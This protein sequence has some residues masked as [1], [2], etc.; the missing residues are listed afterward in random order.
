MLKT[1]RALKMMAREKF[2][3]SQ[4]RRAFAKYSKLGYPSDDDS[5]E[6]DMLGS[7]FELPAMK[8]SGKY[9]RHF[10]MDEKR[11]P[12]DSMNPR[13]SNLSDMR[14]IKDSGSPLD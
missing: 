1:I 6:E 4:W 9:G 3:S 13:Q 2:S 8:N 5:D 14:L 11:L 12:N 10:V 7:H